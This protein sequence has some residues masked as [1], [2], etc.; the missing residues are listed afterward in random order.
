VFDVILE[1]S[2]YGSTG[3]PPVNPF[4][5]KNL[6]KWGDLVIILLSSRCFGFGTQ[7]VPASDAAASGLRKKPPA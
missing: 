7:W 3:V 6:V 2:L 5:L 1:A 4:K